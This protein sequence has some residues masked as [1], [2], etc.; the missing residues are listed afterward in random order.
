MKNCQ[1]TRALTCPWTESKCTVFRNFPTANTH[2]RK[3]FFFFLSL[4]T[5]ELTFLPCYFNIVTRLS[6]WCK[7]HSVCILHY[8]FSRCLAQWAPG[9]P[10]CSNRSRRANPASL[11]GSIFPRRQCRSYYLRTSFSTQLWIFCWHKRVFVCLWVCIFVCVYVFVSV[12]WGDTDRN[13]VVCSCHSEMS[14][15]MTCC[16]LYGVNFFSFRRLLQTHYLH[17]RTALLSIVNINHKARTIKLNA[18]QCF[19]F[20]EGPFHT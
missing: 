19:I 15:F 9:I 1:V 8:F 17:I 5:L 16:L 12:Y 10:G 18:E 3:V 7:T 20:Q 13:L 2:R 6:S 14:I 4:Q 11:C